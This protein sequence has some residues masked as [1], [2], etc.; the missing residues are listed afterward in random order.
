MLPRLVVSREKDRKVGFGGK[1]DASMAEKPFE[2]YWRIYLDACLQTKGGLNTILCETFPE[3]DAAQNY[4]N[5]RGSIFGC[6]NN[7]PSKAGGG[8]ATL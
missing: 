3:E 2:V 4:W 1:A 5:M 7:K 6:R 8:M